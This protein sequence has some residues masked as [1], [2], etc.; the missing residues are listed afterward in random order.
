MKYFY[1]SGG[2]N[3]PYFPHR[4]KVKKCTNKMYEWCMHY[5]G[6]DEPFKNFHVEWDKYKPGDEMHIGYEIVQFQSEN[7]YLAFLYAF[8]GE[9]IAANSF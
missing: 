8:A 4:V 6:D 3:K 7:A 2:N 1:S 9:Y 5:P